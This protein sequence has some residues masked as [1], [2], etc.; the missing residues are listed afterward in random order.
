MTASISL[1]CADVD[2][3]A[4]VHLVRHACSPVPG[5]AEDAQARHLLAVCS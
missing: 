3:V 5:P 4:V 2:G 1:D